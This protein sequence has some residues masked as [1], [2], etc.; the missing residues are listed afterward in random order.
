MCLFG[1]G[2]QQEYLLSPLLYL[3]FEKAI[4]EKVI[5][6]LHSSEQLKKGRDGEKVE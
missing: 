1:R 6:M 4:S 2:V 3:I 5:A